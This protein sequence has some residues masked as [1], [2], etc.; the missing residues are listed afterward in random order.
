MIL[1]EQVYYI[2]TDTVDIRQSTAYHELAPFDDHDY[3]YVEFLKSLGKLV[4]CL[5]PDNMLDRIVNGNVHLILCN[6]HEAFHDV[7][8]EIYQRAVI[9]LAIPAHKILLLSESAD[10]LAEVKTVATRLQMAEIKT[11]Y[12][13]IF[14]WNGRNRIL[15][16]S[17][18]NEERINATNSTNLKNTS[19]TKSFLNLNRRWRLHRPALVAL[20][21]AN[22]LLD[23]G[24]V[25]LA[26]VEGYT[27]DSIWYGLTGSH[28]VEIN[29]I[30]KAHG[31]DIRAL[32]P[33]YLDTTDLITNRAEYS[34]KTRY[35]Y[36]DSY[37]SVVS[38]TNYYADTPGRFLSEKVFKPILM[39]HPFMM[40][41]RPHSLKLLRELGYKTFEPYIDESYDSIEDDSER[42][43]VIVKE[44]KRL[45]YLSTEEL[46][47]FLN[48]TAEI[49]RHNF[50]TLEQKTNFITR[51]N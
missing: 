9:E 3:I 23:K 45:S 44:I 16:T 5:T 26:P 13:R 21:F 35:L 19:F 43:L 15:N 18:L 30:L 28:N 47:D 32:P 20:L 1:N 10:I 49:C 25:S 51:L 6:S 12:T 33:M 39:L 41:S 29:T 40:V 22:K 7:V 36:N 46:Q 2:D 4:E 38:E 24:H 8:A 42:L 48:G 14:E 27:W 11:V 50:Q 34:T 37:F 17:P 31:A